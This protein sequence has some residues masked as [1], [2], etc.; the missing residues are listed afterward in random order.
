MLK[1]L[2]GDL[3]ASHAQ[4]L[5]NPV[6]CAGV[7]GKGVA[8]EFKMRF[9]A[10]FHD[11]AQ[12]CKRR[13]VRLGEPYA[14]RDGSGVLIVNFPTKGHWRSPSRLDDI[15][16]GLDYLV[17]HVGDWD[18]QSLALP[19]LGCGNGG[20][21]WADVGPLIDRKLSSLSIDVELYAPSGAKGSQLK[22]G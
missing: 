21:A 3:F 1:T 8:L 6:N 20:L 18:I 2:T 16:R 10:M 14:Y 12:R 17:D 5:V 15:G 7:M 19:A 4:A 22:I 9:P 13:S 11:Y